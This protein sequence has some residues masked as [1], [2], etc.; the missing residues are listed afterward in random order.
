MA[1]Q[2]TTLSVAGPT[3]HEVAV[4]AALSIGRRCT[5]ETRVLL[6]WRWSRRRAPRSPGR[7]FERASSPPA[8]VGP[9]RAA[10]W[11][12]TSGVPPTAPTPPAPPEG[13]S[14]R[15]RARVS[16]RVQGVFYRASA[17]ERA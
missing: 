14:A 15:V 12:Y 10:L 16:G 4:E 7:A 6:E 3:R 1:E 5:D 8:D 17:A 2:R 13:G 9:S 11:I